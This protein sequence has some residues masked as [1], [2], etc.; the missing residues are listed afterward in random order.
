MLHR[1]GD[2]TAE[3]IRKTDP[4][5]DRFK[6]DVGTGG[7]LGALILLGL[8]MQPDAEDSSHFLA[9]VFEAPTVAEK[10]SFT[11]CAFP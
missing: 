5:D 2:S 4:D 10:K 1:T 7:A 9:R 8:S 6:T 3:P 11:D